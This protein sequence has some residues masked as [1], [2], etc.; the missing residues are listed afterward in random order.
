MTLTLLLLLG[1]C[2]D[3]GLLVRDPELLPPAHPGAGRLHDVARPPLA[4][5]GADRHHLY[6]GPDCVLNTN[7]ALTSGVTSVSSSD[8]RSLFI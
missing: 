7:I 4:G 2:Q 1:V 6:P 3:D 8:T 5:A